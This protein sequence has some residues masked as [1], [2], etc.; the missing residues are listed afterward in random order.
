M[1]SPLQLPKSSPSQEPSP[2]QR[3][4]CVVGSLG[5][6]KQKARGIVH[7]ALFIG[8]P[9]GSLCGGHSRG[10]TGDATPSGLIFL[11]SL[12]FALLLARVASASVRLRS[13]EQGTRVFPT[14]TLATH[15][16]PFP[17]VNR[18]RWR[19]GCVASVSVRF[20]SKERGGTRVK[21]RAKNGVSKRALSV[22]G[23]CFISRRPKSRIPFLDL[24][25]LRNQTETL[26]TQAKWRDIFVSKHP[27]VNH[28]QNAPSERVPSSSDDKEEPTATG[29]YTVR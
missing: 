6:K 28:H 15:A 23:S 12:Y 13:K 16:M 21:D 26:V 10:R 2:P 9:S 7:R 11:R 18:V 14:G 5:R 1:T 27:H 24:S 17:S 19:V 3:P 22:F 20:R 4:L 29:K 25:L 8:I